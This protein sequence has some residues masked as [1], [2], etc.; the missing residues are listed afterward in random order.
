MLRRT[1][2]AIV[3]LLTAGIAH[4][5]SK[6]QLRG[7]LYRI[8]GE[9]RTASLHTDQALEHAKAAERFAHRLSGQLSGDPQLA[10]YG[11]RVS[12]AADRLAHAAQRVEPED[13]RAAAAD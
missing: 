4:G 7:L 8:D 3:A 9:V 11:A 2:V 12:A 13:V 1:M 5:N 6:D 10:W